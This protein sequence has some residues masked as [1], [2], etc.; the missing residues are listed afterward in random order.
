MGCKAFI[1]IKVSK[2]G[3]NLEIKDLDLDHSNHP[4]TEVGFCTYIFL[5]ILL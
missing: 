5:N 2:D 1:T 4:G 3:K